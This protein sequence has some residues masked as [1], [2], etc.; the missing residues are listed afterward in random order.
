MEVSREV[1]EG[2]HGLIAAERLVGGD[3]PRVQIIELVSRLKLTY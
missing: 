3:A 2:G 1:G